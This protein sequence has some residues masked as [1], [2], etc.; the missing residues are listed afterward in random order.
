[1]NQLGQRHPTSR[2]IQTMAGACFIGGE[3]VWLRLEAP[4]LGGSYWALGGQL[5]LGDYSSKE[6]SQV[7]SWETGWEGAVAN[8]QYLIFGVAQP[9]IVCYNS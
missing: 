6:R 1:M 7:V 5:G 4:I 9:K 2:G 3:K 8:A